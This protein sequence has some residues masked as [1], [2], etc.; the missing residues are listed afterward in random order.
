MVLPVA[1]K[2]L[3]AD[4]PV[5]A[6]LAVGAELERVSKCVTGTLVPRVEAVS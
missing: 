6:R 4:A 2:L 1:A 5:A 3:D